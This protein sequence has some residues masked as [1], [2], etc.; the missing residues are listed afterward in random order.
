M[1]NSKEKITGHKK[2]RKEYFP[3][4]NANGNLNMLMK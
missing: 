1:V 4:Q 3:V 2:K